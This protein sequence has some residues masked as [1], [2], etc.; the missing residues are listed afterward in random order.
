MDVLSF[1]ANYLSMD[2]PL[3]MQP[4]FVPSYTSSFVSK[5]VPSMYFYSISFY[6]SM[7]IKTKGLSICHLIQGVK[8]LLTVFRNHL[9]IKHLFGVLPYLSS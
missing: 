8:L 5:S 4:R 6:I 1:S 3:I 7:S 2:H 9:D